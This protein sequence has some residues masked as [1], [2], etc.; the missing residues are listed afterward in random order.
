VNHYSERKD[1][2]NERGRFDAPLGTRE[3]LEQRR[4]RKKTFKNIHLLPAAM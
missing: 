4:Q 3:Q 1:E 2:W